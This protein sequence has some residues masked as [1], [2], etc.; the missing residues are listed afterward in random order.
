MTTDKTTAS[1]MSAH[2]RAHD[3]PTAIRHPRRG[4]AHRSTLAIGV[5][6]GWAGDTAC[7]KWARDMTERLPLSQIPTTDLCRTCWPTTKEN[8]DA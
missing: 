1:H 3:E 6:A 5:P 7:G 8:L 2:E 4:K